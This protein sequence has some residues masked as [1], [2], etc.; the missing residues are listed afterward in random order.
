MAKR[1]KTKNT[2]NAQKKQEAP[3]KTADKKKNASGQANALQEELLE[4]LTSVS[5]KMDEQQASVEKAQQEVRALETALEEREA[6]L[7]A[8]TEALSR[9]EADASARE[10]DLA[11]REAAMETQQEALEVL[12]A[13]VGQHGQLVED[14]LE[15]LTAWEEALRQQAQAFEESLAQLD[16]NTARLEDKQQELDSRT[17][18]V[19]EQEKALDA[20][21][22]DLEEAEI[23]LDRWSA[24]TTALAG[25]V[26]DHGQ[27]LE[28][29]ARGLHQ[30]LNRSRQ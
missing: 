5:Q 16:E 15:K 17:A 26:R 23:W 29:T 11:A 20:R 28:E 25:T 10:A 8:G 7:A 19:A 4:K 30:L 9:R 21:R 2:D 18:E 24:E 27:R 14:L 3:E 22:Q 6:K 12:A 13:S 1:S